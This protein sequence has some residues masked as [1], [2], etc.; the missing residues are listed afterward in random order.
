MITFGVKSEQEQG[1]LAYYT[2][3]E[4]MLIDFAATLNRCWRLPNKFTNFTAQTKVDAIADS[5]TTSH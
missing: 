3:V 5:E 2:L 4:W 1:R